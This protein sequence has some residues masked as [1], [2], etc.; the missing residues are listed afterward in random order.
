MIR[1]A[2]RDPSVPQRGRG[3]NFAS[4]LIGFFVIL[5]AAGIVWYAR[6]PVG[7]NIQRE[8]IKQPLGQ[9][10]RAS[11]ELQLG[12][13]RLELDATSHRENL[14]DGEVEILSGLEQLKQQAIPQGQGLSY[15]L[16]AQ[17]PAAVREP[18]RWPT[19]DLHLN[20]SVPLNLSVSGGLGASQLNVR[21]LKLEHLTLSSEAARYSVTLPEHGQVQVSLRG[22]SSRMEVKIPDRMALRLLV[23]DN[24]AGQVQLDQRLIRNG[25]AQ[26]T[27]GF[28]TA[29]DR[30]DLEATTGLGHINIER[31]P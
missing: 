15:L 9:A 19:W 21:Q 17:R 13:T 29:L 25:Q 11:I 18:A 8:V 27:P 10:T 4:L 1:T 28:D 2:N 12:A 16:R 14:I 5:A 31:I 26:V 30:V 22:G 3:L 23:T 20:P 6:L 7:T 24:A